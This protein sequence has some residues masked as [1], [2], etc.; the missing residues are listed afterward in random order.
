MCEEVRKK[1]I[2]GVPLIIID[3]KWAVK[4]GQSSDVFVQVRFFLFFSR[5]RAILLRN[6][7]KNLILL[8]NID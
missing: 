6:S 5:N 1:G 8:A 4:G 3:G 7:K 2:N